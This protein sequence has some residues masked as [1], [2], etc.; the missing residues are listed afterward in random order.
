MKAL[1]DLE[2]E[3]QVLASALGATYELAKLGFGGE[4]YVRLVFLQDDGSY[5]HFEMPTD[6]PH[7]QAL[8]RL[9]LMK[10]PP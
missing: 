10:T 3:A 7:W 4:P 2:N 5:Y 6:G 1:A 8:V 9:A